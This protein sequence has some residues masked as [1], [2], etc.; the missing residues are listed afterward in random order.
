MQKLCEYYTL[1]LRV[2]RFVGFKNIAF[3]G[4]LGTAIVVE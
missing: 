4:L 2:A 3:F 1:G